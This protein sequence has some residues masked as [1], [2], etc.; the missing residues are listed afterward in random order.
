MLIPKFSIR[1]LLLMMVAVGVVSAC[2]A[3][4]Y[5]G[6]TVAFGLAMGMMATIFP[7]LAYAIVHWVA[8]GIAELTNLVFKFPSTPA[9]M[10]NDVGSHHASQGRGDA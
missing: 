10:A 6:S 7:F 8:L 1:Q 9:E 5:R 2:L 4:A 3:G